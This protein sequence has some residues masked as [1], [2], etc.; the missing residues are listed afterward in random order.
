MEYPIL[1]S[2]SNI[3]ATTGRD[4]SDTDSSDSEAHIEEESTVTPESTLR[5]STRVRKK[6]QWFDSYVV[7]QQ[8]IN[9]LLQIHLQNNRETMRLVKKTMFS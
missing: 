1:Y 9:D 5:R 2:R 3:S 8:Q 7:G 6:P 4:R